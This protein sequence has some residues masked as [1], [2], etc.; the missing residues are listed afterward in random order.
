MED[1]IILSMK[2]PKIK[3]NTPTLLFSADVHGISF[4]SLE[5]QIVGYPGPWLL[6]VSHTET[7]IE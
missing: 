3:E 6:V 1:W 5:G 4:S 7:D 2:A